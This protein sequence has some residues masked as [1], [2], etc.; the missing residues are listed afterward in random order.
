MK[1][2]RKTVALCDCEATMTLDAA[3]LARVC[4]A[5]GSDGGAVELHTQLCRSQIGKFQRLIAADGPL[6]VACTQEAPLFDEARVEAGKA[7]LPVSYVNIRERAGWSDE[8]AHAAPKIAALLAEA[9]LDFPPT[10]S[11]GLESKG[12][13]LIYGRDERAIEIARRLRDRLDVTVMLD[14][15][16]AVAPPRAMDV[17]IYKGTIVGA[18]GHLGGFEIVVDDYAAPLPS[19]RRQLVFEPP[20]KGASATCDL[21]LDL[22]GGTPLFPA[23]EKRDGYL[24]PDPGD[25][26]AVERAVFALADLVGT[27]D[28]PRY[29]D[30]HADLCA[31]QRSRKTGCTRCL[32]VCPVGAIAPAGDTVAIDERVCAGCGACA[33]VCPTGAASYAL[34]AGGALFQRLRTLLQAYR[35]A[36]GSDPVL[37]L[38][39]TSH[40]EEMVAAIARQGRGLPARVLPFA[41]NSITQVGLDFL[42]CALAYGATQLRV[43]AGPKNRGELDGLAQQ[44]GLV[45]T[46]MA[47]LGYSGGRVAIVDAAD[48]EQVEAALYDLP[49]VAAPAPGTFLPM[50]GKRTLTLLA[51]RHLRDHAPAPAEILPLPHG[52]PFGALAIDAKGCTLCL[53]CVGACPTGALGDNPDRPTLTFTEDACVQCGICRSTCPEKVIALAPRFNFADAARSPV[54]VKQ[55]PPFHCVRCG[56]PFGTRGAIE[57]IVEKLAGK[58]AMFM[59]GDA[60]FRLMMCEDCRVVV[61][62][63]QGNDPFAGKPRPLPRTSEDDFREREVLE[64]RAR[65]EKERAKDREGG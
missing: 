35:A 40:G 8:G 18:R 43:L 62:F 34:P 42:S 63:E 6:L 38:H 5:A 32:D 60:R 20:R 22:T 7:E 31:H 59:Q 50:G 27:F 54:V 11:V 47:G 33:S 15:P 28:K 25:A 19:S 55:E 12:V 21:I 48:P 36:G 56:K 44:I 2:N 3:S 39:D 61:Q 4:G 46:A 14:R 45:E 13:T 65:L 30:F 16:D 53:A 52:A 37:L 51:L 41:V 1:F 23:H 24:R 57:R 29:V 58:H 64:A 10:A 9:A 49:R 26:A 17:P